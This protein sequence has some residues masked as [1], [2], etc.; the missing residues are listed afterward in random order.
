MNITHSVRTRKFKIKSVNKK[1]GRVVNNC[2]VSN[3]NSRGNGANNSKFVLPDWKNWLENVKKFYKT[4]RVVNIRPTTVAEV[5]CKK[6]FDN[7]PYIEIQILDSKI[8]ILLD[9]GANRS[10]VGR[11]G[12]KLLN[13][14][15]LKIN[16]VA[17]RYVTTADGKKN[18][19]KGSVWL[20]LCVNNNLKL[21][22]VLVVPSL[23]HNF[24]FGADFCKL[25]G[26][27]VDFSSDTWHIS[28]DSIEINVISEN[29]TELLS[30]AKYTPQQKL[31]IDKIISEFRTLS[32]ENR[33]GRT[34]VMVHHINTGDAAPFKQKQYLMSP[35]MLGHLN[36]ELDKMLKL[37]VVEASHSDWCSPVLLVK[38]NSGEYRFC[39]DGRKLNSVTKRDSYPLPHV[40]RILNMLRDS[41]FISTIDLKS[42]FW[43]IPLDDSSKEKTAF[44]VPGRGLFHFCVLPFGLSNSALVQQRL[45]DKIL[46]P[47][48][49]PKVFV[50][51]DDIIIT[52]STFEEHINIL[53][54]VHKRLS[55][56]N[57]TV[58]LE[59]CIFFRQSLKYLGFVVDSDG[60]R[61]N[62]EKVEAMVNY[63]RPR[64]STE[65]KRFIGMCS[66][67][68]RFIPHFSTLVSPLNDLLKGKKKRQTITWND[69]AEK[70]FLIIKN[71]LVSAPILTTADFNLPFTIQCDASDTGLGGTLTQCQDGVEKVI[72]FASRS[73]SRA[74]RNYSVSE[75][76][77]LAVLFCIEKYRPFL[78]GSKF[79]VITDH[80]S[81]LWLQRM[82]EPT[83]RLARWAVKLQQFDFEIV[84]RKGK[85][86]VVPDALSRIH[87]E[88]NSLEIDLEK[89]ETF[90]VQLKNKVLKNPERYPQW[91]VEGD[92]LYKHVSSKIPLHTNISEW[93][94]LVPKVYRKDIMNLC[95][96]EPTSAHFGFYKTL[97]RISEEYYWPRMR[98]DILRYVKFCHTCNEQKISN[99]APLGLMGNEKNVRFPWQV[100]SADI[101]GPLPR[102]TAGHCYLLV[103]TD[104]LT[105]YVLLH[106]LRQA[107]AVSVARFMENQVFLVYGVPQFI[108]CD[109]G[110]QFAGTIFKKLANDYKVQKI[111][112]NARYHPQ[113]NPT[114]RVNAT[115]GPAI[116]SYIND[117]HRVWDKNIH[118]IAFAIRTAIHEVTGYSPAFLN[119]GRKLPIS[120]D[121]YGKVTSTENIQLQPTSRENLATDLGNLKEIFKEVQERISNS[122][123]KN[124]NRYNLRRR[125]V[126]FEVGDK[127]W[128]RNKAL[129]KAANHF[130]AKLAPKYT[131]CTVIRKVGRLVYALKHEDG[132]Y[133]GEWHVK[134]LKPYYGSNSDVSVG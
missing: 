10:V 99:R 62:P 9:S 92:Y 53:R 101:M 123:R 127:V 50:Y 43:Q 72:S 118:K 37:G 54:E 11:G 57:V 121:Y 35:F 58:N 7:R 2:S 110:T 28:Q 64:T 105:K 39:F 46:G 111:W 27:I 124:A 42:A 91:K 109:N 93:K 69:S 5:I 113:V 84:H 8:V 56:A 14:F 132:S 45:M 55:N 25:F 128:K 51:L 102:S 76:E 104:W 125:D 48:M 114:E 71:A 106:P 122:Y 117:N 133:L 36:K 86:H 63:P 78:E 4:K 29:K 38:K 119:F 73:L 126:T 77:A 67:Y 107:T 96:N 31:E 108:I 60:L 75:R 59:K 90:Y 116:R 32:D 66:W 103:V 130:S 6:P 68:R 52:S 19:I 22:E 74:E 100:I 16:K 23:E 95:H 82:K 85:C 49:E 61:T 12:I 33:L 26:V 21:F 131:L 20:P 18:E 15:K 98:R 89:V 87:T 120:G 129:S 44:A 13:K 79:T 65:I 41:K 134:H 47:E 97:K 112:F 115:L 17:E 3:V 1:K 81:L 30:Q 24:I 34:H 70:S 40:D 88:V 80:Y 94:I 83:G